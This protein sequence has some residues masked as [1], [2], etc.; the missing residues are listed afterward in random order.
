MT[1]TTS[2]VSG[3]T[4]ICLIPEH[5]INMEIQQLEKNVQIKAVIIWLISLLLI[6]PFLLLITAPIKRLS[7]QMSKTGEGDFT[8]RAHEGGSLEICELSN[9]FNSMVKHIYKLIRKTYIAE[10]NAKDARLA[11][12][13]AQINPHFLYN[14]LQAIST[15][16]LLN[17][18]MKIHRMITSLA[19][20]LRYTIKGSVL[21]PLSAEMEYV[22]NYIFLQEMRK[23]DIFEFH[24][25]IDEAAENCMI[26]KISIQTLIENS[27]IHGRSQNDFQIHISLTVKKQEDT[28]VITEEDDGCGI[29]EERLAAIQRSFEVQKTTGQDGIGLA[30]L[31]NRLQILYEKPTNF[32][33]ESKEGV[34]TRI[35]L[36][37]PAAPNHSK[38]IFRK[39]E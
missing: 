4:F 23:D 10:L 38:D 29:S 25:D 26:P 15:E 27:I 2:Q 33:I 14:T 13:E 22:K 30:N 12:L 8:T 16:A 36:V 7:L 3:I 28:I 24:A 17:D 34:Y 21:V 39:K 31:Y 5:L 35:T 6:Y 1:S 32:K 37:L 11:A 19:S 20:N 18:Q 9:S